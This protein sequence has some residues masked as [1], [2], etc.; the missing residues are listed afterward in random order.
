MSNDRYRQT[1]PWLPIVDGARP[2]SSV[3]GRPRASSGGTG[4]RDEVALWSE[5]ELADLESSAGGLASAV[6]VP[7]AAPPRGRVRLGVLL[8]CLFVIGVGGGYLVAQVAKDARAASASDAAASWDN[9]AMDLLDASVGAD[10]RIE[11]SGALEPRRSRELPRSGSAELEAMLHVR[12]H[13]KRLR[14]GR[15][16]VEEV[17][18]TSGELVAER[19]VRT[20]ELLRPGHPKLVVL[21]AHWCEPCKDALHWLRDRDL[22]PGRDLVVVSEQ[23]FGGEQRKVNDALGPRPGWLISGGLDVTSYAEELGFAESGLPVVMVLDGDD[24][25]LEAWRSKAPAGLEA[26][27]AAVQRLACEG[28]CH[29]QTVASPE[30]DGAYRADQLA[31]CAGLARPRPPAPNVPSKVV[32]TSESEPPSAPPP[33]DTSTLQETAGQ[34]AR[35][36]LPALRLDGVDQAGPRGVR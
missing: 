25:I 24:R 20:Q 17:R 14:L 15:C 26:A 12:P 21:G 23:A 3:A 10:Q 9:R 16:S 6:A 35:T 28:P 33:V 2:R 5:P 1:D 19:A 32:G 4:G 29:Q 27:V 36:P 34:P 8:P 30:V 18:G 13:G 7:A 22:G 31:E 11:V